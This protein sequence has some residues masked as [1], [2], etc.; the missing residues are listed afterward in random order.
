MWTTAFR[1]QPVTPFGVLPSESGHTG[2]PGSCPAGTGS[3]SKEHHA[4]AHA[5]TISPSRPPPHDP[6]LPPRRACSGR[7]RKSRQRVARRWQ[8]TR[9]HPQQRCTQAGGWWARRGSTHHGRGLRRMSMFGGFKLAYDNWVSA[10]DGQ[11]KESTLTTRCRT[12]ARVGDGCKGYEV[13]IELR[14]E[15]R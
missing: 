11:R 7:G 9:S 14:S 2:G 15:L 5:I 1:A 10:S 12:A 8:A 3:N 6:S 4:P 13:S